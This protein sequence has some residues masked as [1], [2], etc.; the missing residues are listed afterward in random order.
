MK[1]LDNIRLSDRD[2]RAVEA[3][4]RLLR[5]RFP[6]ETVILFGS[7]ARG[8]DDPES[9]MDLL[10]L[11]TR[12]LSWQ[13]KKELIYSLFDVEIEHDVVISTLIATRSEWENGYFSVLPIHEEIVEEGA[14]V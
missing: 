4:C 9:D 1:T 6:L 2:R 12:P 3:A 13:E 8:N 7:K 10:V 5:E 14:I 11:T